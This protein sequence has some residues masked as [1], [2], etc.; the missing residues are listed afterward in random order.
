MNTTRNFFKIRLLFPSVADDNGAAGP[1]Q[2]THPSRRQL[3]RTGREGLQ[4]IPDS[5]EICAEELVPSVRPES[6]E[7]WPLEGLPLFWSLVEDGED[8]ER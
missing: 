4:V 3:V 7:G 8:D 5:D 6:V 1:R 2:R